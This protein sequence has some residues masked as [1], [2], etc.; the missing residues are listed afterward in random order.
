[1]PSHVVSATRLLNACGRA[2]CFQGR[3]I[4]G[5]W[6]SATPCMELDVLPWLL[7]SWGVRTG[8]DLPHACQT[9]GVFWFTRL[10]ARNRMQE[11]VQVVREM[12]QRLMGDGLLSCGRLGAVWR[13]SGRCE[14]LPGQEVPAAS[15]HARF[16][17][18]EC[19]PTRTTQAM[20][21]H[22]NG[23]KQV[24]TPRITVPRALWFINPCLDDDVWHPLN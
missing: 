19:A 5:L 11:R 13:Q 10:C 7:G 6:T 1:M 23:D 17:S 8:L 21:S 9:T 16:Q 12:S 20:L 3:T 2:A 22:R 14:A 15:A 18:A 24:S 4:P